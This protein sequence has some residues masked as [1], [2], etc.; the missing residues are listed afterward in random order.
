MIKNILKALKD[1]AGSFKLMSQL[2]LWKYFMVPMAISIL[3]AVT[4]G[5]AA[6]GLSDDLAGPLTRLWIWET[7]AETFFAFAEVLSA[8]IIVLLGLLVYKHFVMAL[9]A[10]FMSPVSEKIEKYLYPE[11]HET[12]THRNTSNASQLS[13]GTRINVRNLFFELPLT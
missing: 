13:R 6:Y 11:I 2:G 9:S 5:F 3:F 12:I 8:I 1:Y 4:I 10:P 7:G